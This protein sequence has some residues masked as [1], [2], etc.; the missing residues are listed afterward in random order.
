MESFNRLIRR[1][2]LLQETLNELHAL[3]PGHPAVEVAIANIV[4]EDQRIGAALDH[5]FEAV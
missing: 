2:L 1:K 5:W 3:L 4:K